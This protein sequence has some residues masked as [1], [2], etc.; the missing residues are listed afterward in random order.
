MR[1]RGDSGVARTV[2]G[3]RELPYPNRGQ[4][5]I[6]RGLKCF[7]ADRPETAVFPRTMPRQRTTRAAKIDEC[8]GCEALRPR[9]CGPP[10]SSRLAC[11]V[12]ESPSLCASPDSRA[13]RPCSL[14]HAS[15]PQLNA[16]RPGGGGSP[17]RGEKNPAP[18]VF[19]LRGSGLL[20]AILRRRRAPPVRFRRPAG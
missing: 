6:D 5:L 20:A 18:A 1:V 2:E 15:R 11:G 17:L 7:R 12:R 4:E 16:S 19:W 3:E 8:R 10:V 13:S 14:R 9:F